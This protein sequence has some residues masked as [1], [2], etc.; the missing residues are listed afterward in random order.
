VYEKYCKFYSDCHLLKQRERWYYKQTNDRRLKQ[1]I[2]VNENGYREKTVFVEYDN[3]GKITTLRVH[4]RNEGEVF[5]QYHYDK[6]GVLLSKVVIIGNQARIYEEYKYQEGTRVGRK[7]NITD[8]LHK[9][10]RLN[11]SILYYDQD[12][13]K[14]YYFREYAKNGKSQD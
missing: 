6:T 4:S 12:Y 3:P 8:S 5:I 9:S 1:R 11:T 14:D 13:L 7:I 10:Y 2:L